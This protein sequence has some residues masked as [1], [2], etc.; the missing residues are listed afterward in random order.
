MYPWAG[1]L[2]LAMKG[3]PRM[4]LYHYPGLWACAGVNEA[5]LALMWTGGG[6]IP[7]VPPVVGVPT[8]ALIAEVMRLASVEGALA[9]LRGVKPAGC[10][11]FFLADASGATAIVEGAAGRIAVEQKPGCMVRA[12]H[13]VCPDIV[14]CSNQERRISRKKY[15][16]LQR[17][18][19]MGELVEQNRGRIDPKTTRAILTDRGSPWPWLH[20]FPGERDSVPLSGMTIDSLFVVCQ[21]RVLETCRGGREPGPWQAITV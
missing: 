12:N 13:Y 11:L 1:L 16:T 9:Y 3:S 14:T 18:A 17:E 20:Q 19:R 8:Y 4:A 21:D 2:K 5:G 6:Y 7:R 10:F 15:S